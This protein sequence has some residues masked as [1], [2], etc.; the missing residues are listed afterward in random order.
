MTQFFFFF[1]YHYFLLHSRIFKY[2][3]NK[4][5][6]SFLAL[7]SPLKTYIPAERRLTKLEVSWL[8]LT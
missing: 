6:V 5:V 8:I 7:N 4:T 3:S 2:F 1:I